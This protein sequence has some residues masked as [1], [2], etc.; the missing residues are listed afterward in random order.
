MKETSRNGHN[1]VTRHE[2]WQSE[3]RLSPDDPGVQEHE[4]ASEI[5]ELVVEYDQLDVSNLA[6]F[7]YFTY[8]SIIIIFKKY[9]YSTILIHIFFSI[10]KS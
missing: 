1:P 2:K 8:I 4:V 7:E 10:I 9:T 5:F 3:S 6:S